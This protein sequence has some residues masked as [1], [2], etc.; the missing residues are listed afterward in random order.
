[1]KNLTNLKSLNL[2]SGFENVC[3]GKQNVFVV[4]QNVDGAAENDGVVTQ[5]DGDVVTHC[6]QAKE[7]D[8]WVKSACGA[9]QS[10]SDEQSLCQ[11]GENNQI[12]PK[13]QC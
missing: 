9:T 6:G 1:M 7:H 4:K 5:N 2:W 12:T 10:G 3:A 13:T 11:K 8:E